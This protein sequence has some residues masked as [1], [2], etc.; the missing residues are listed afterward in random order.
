LGLQQLH[1]GPAPDS[2][3]TPLRGKAKDKGRS[4]V[5]HD[6]APKKPSVRL[7]HRLALLRGPVF[8]LESPAPEPVCACVPEHSAFPG[9]IA[10]EI[11][12][13]HARARGLGRG[14]SR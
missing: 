14:N 11:T 3:V 6:W 10:Q 12:D 2:D 8:F 13:G 9:Q 1:L 5:D 4:P 7:P